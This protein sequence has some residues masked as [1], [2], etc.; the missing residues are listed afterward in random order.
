MAVFG[1]PVLHEDDAL[2]AVRAA[3]EMR[4]AMAEL[5][6]EL[7]R[8]L[9]VGLE[10]RIGINTGEVAGIDGVADHG[11]VSGDAVN[12]AARLQAAAPPGGIVIGPQTRR[13][14]EGA[15][16]LRSHGP[17]EAKGKRRP[18]RVWQ[19]ERLVDT[20]GPVHAAARPSRW[21]AGG[22][23]CDMLH[24]PVSPRSGPRPLRARHGRGAGRDREVAHPEGVRGEHRGRGDRRRRALPALRRGDHV[25]AADR[26]RER[27]RRRHGHPRDRGPPGR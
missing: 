3:V 27:P 14:V 13:L 7:E 9:G 23:S 11:F 1:I 26:D 5:N 8:D 4:D 10:L 22:P 21:S 16:R 15:V 25:L 12:T 2:R 20:A 24:D 6:R 18:L 17:V 19:V